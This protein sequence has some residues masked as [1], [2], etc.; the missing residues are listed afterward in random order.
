MSPRER[1]LKTLAHQEPDR[2]PLDL[3]IKA[4]DPQLKAMLAAS[5]L[6][7]ETKGRLFDG[8][9]EY[10]YF[11]PRKE[12]HCFTPY[13]SGM[14][15]EAAVGDWGVGELRHKDSGTALLT[16]HIFSPLKQ[17]EKAEEL[18]AYPW[19]DMTD[20]RR[21]GHLREEI[22][23][24]HA[25]GKPVIGQMSQTLVETAY[26]LRTME[27]LFLDFYENPE[28]VERLFEIITRARCIQARTFAELGVDVLRIGDD[29]AT[30]QAL[31]VSLATY[32]Q[33]IK[34]RHA[35]IVAAAR[36]LRPDLP[37]L[38]HSDGNIE[39][40][41]PE[42]LEIGVTAV[43]PVQPECVDPVAVKERWGQR[44][45]LWG[46]VSNQH[47]I[48]FGS[49]EEVDAEVEAR[50]GK[51]APGGGYVLNFIN[52]VWSPTARKNVLRYASRMDEMG[53]Y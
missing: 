45:T 15:R 10:V 3:R 12:T 41:I 37:V 18:E 44:I 25:A 48:A 1:L 20:P 52:V 23:A 13:L 34:P 28:F 30:Q 39:S 47:T 42:L 5:T 29:L 11:K 7:A 53:V 24:A 33:W 22:G 43:N 31:M 4:A 9:V 36:E 6:R 8:D 16:E 19:P 51:L 49:A 40:L 2:V 27:R 17:M 32:R 14:P 35:R 38:Y 50:W 21:W 46:A 26:L